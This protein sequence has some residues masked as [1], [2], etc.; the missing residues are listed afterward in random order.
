VRKP[1][2]RKLGMDTAIDRLWEV[3]ERETG[4][5]LEVRAPAA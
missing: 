2:F 3:S 4:L 1:I 5:A